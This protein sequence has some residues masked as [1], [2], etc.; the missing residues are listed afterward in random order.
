MR[1]YAVLL[2]AV[3]LFA[4]LPA[5]SGDRFWQYS[6]N[7]SRSAASPDRRRYVKLKSATSDLLP[8]GA[9]QSRR[10]VLLSAVPFGDYSITVTASGFS[11]A[12][13]TLTLASD[14]SSV[15][16]FQLAIAAV[17]ETTVVT[18]AAR[19]AAPETVTPTTLV[20]RQDIARTPGADLT[21]SLAM[22]T[23]FT[24]GAYMTHDMLH[25][26]GGHQTS[27]AHRRRSHPRPEHRHQPCSA[28]RSQDIDDVEIL[29]GSYDAQYGDRTYGMFNILPSTG[30]DMNNEAELSPPSAAF[31]KPT[32]SSTSAGTRKGSPTTRASTETAAI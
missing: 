24:P 19:T 6:W 12:K 32:I 3:V 29:R 4:A 15:L 22:I 2:C 14:T 21:N 31:T 1:K 17:T 18:A 27:L 28:R 11:A 26:R 23:D 20:D 9:N 5:R 25:M 16:H 10:R 7:R 13:Q 8:V 30:F